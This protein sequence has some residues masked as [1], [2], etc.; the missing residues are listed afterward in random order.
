MQRLGQPLGHVAGFM[1]SD[2]AEWRVGTEGS[3][4]DFAE[5]LGTVDDEQPASFGVEPAF[6]DL[7]K[8]F[9]SKLR[10]LDASYLPCQSACACSVALRVQDPS[11]WRRLGFLNDS[12]G[13][14]RKS[15]TIAKK[16]HQ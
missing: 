9:G 16:D 5:R 8:A 13:E 1:N 12:R 14:Q 4:D 10:M 3:T 2:S 11:Q 6:T 15:Q 7:R